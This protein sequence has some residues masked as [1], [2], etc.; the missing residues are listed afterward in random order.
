[1]SFTEHL[2]PAAHPN[3]VPRHRALCLALFGIGA[4][5][6]H[7]AKTLMPD[8][9]QRRGPAPAARLGRRPA[10]PPSTILKE[11]AA[12]SGLG[13]RPLIRQHARSARS[14]WSPLPV[15]VLLP[16]T[17][18]RCPGNDAVAR[19]SGSKGTRLVTRPATAAR[20]R[21]SD[22]HD[23]L[24]R[25]HPARGPRQGARRR[26]RRRPR[27]PSC[28]CGST[29]TSSDA[30]VAAGLGLRGHRRLL[31]DLHPRRLP[32]RPCTSSRPT[33]CSA[34]ATSRRST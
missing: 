2:D 19:R 23:R 18:A 24:G 8:E 25:P 9:E 4:G 21:P 10:R 31:Q 30:E 27:P 17:S 28:C 34:R 3:L 29:P 11:G 33:T 32:G 13:R 7:W 16:A 20:S 12:E 22:V 26:S 15:V 14:P 6:V 5:A 1:M